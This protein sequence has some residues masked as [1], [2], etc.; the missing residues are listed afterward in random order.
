MKYSIHTNNDKVAIALGHNEPVKFTLEQAIQFSEI[1]VGAL[2]DC[3]A[4]QGEPNP[5]DNPYDSLGVSVDKQ[6]AS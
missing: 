5:F 6:A 2:E 4:W 3:Q 1:L